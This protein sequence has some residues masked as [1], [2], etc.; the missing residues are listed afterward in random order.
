M[1]AKRFISWFGIGI[2][3]ILFFLGISLLVTNSLMTNRYSGIKEVSYPKNINAID[4]IQWADFPNSISLVGSTEN[5]TQSFLY[6]LDLESGKAKIMI[7][8]YR[9]AKYTWNY[10]RTMI[11]FWGRNL[12]TGFEGVGILQKGEKN[13]RE[14]NHELGFPDSWSPDD[15]FLAID[16]SCEAPRHA[17]SF[18]FD[19]ESTNHEVLSIN[20]ETKSFTDI[21]WSPDGKKI[22]F[23][24]GDPFDN[25]EMY[26]LYTMD[27]A[28]HNFDLLLG[29][30][31]N[32]IR[33]SQPK[34]I[35]DGKWLVYK[36]EGSSFESQLRFIQSQQKN[37]Q[38][39]P[40]SRLSPIRSYDVVEENENLIFVIFGENQKLFTL[41]F[42]QAIS[43]LSFE[44]IFLCP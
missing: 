35:L 42:E 32:G 7:P 37:C 8:N 39:N 20:G 3:V 21:T 6:E 26:G 25:K 11:A 16:G 43:P 5:G 27:V 23:V 34:W 19:M 10:H 30:N 13:V 41:N 38:I 29:V 17:C 2:M 33:I 12:S 4:Q 44:E 22:A 1:D 40:L 18:L 24:Y 36:Y 28:N 31:E 9:L 15:R 14:I